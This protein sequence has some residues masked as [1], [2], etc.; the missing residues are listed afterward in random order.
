ML[1][2]TLRA[3]DTFKIGQ[4]M[5]YVHQQ[6]R[7]LRLLIDAPV[8]VMIRRVPTVKA[9]GVRPSA[10]STSPSVLPSSP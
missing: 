8:E 6:G 5:V 2:H 4:A 9:A 1:V 7:K 10:D 3:G